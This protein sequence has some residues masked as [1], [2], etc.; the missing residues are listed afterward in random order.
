M[1]HMKQ[2]ITA[3]KNGRGIQIG[4]ANGYTVS[5]GFGP[6]H[7]CENYDADYNAEVKPTST[8]E[9]AIL[10]KG[11]FVCLPYDVA[12]NVPV[13]QLGDLVAAVESS[14]WARVCHLCG[15]HDD[16]HNNKFPKKV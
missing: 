6:S 10:N 2:T 1:A 5:I 7:Y 13:S 16:D 8:M 9:V 11:H 4:T 14:D 15:E 12:A 3:M